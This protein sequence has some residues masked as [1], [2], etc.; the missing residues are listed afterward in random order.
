[1]LYLA[2]DIINKTLVSFNGSSLTV[3]G[4]FQ[5]N[6]LSLQLQFV[7]SVP[8]NSVVPYQTVDMNVTK[9]RVTISN[10]VTG[11]LASETSYELAQAVEAAFTW[12]A[13]NEWFTGVINLDTTQMATYLGSNASQPA[14][15]EVNVTT[16][17][18]DPETMFQG[19]VTVFA[20]ADSG[21]A[22]ST[23][24]VNG[25]GG[26]LALQNGVGGVTIAG[27]VITVAGL[28]WGTVPNA[29]LIFI[30]EPAAGN[31]VIFANY[32]IGSATGAGFQFELSGAPPN[33]N[34]TF[35]YV[36]VFNAPVF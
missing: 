4:L 17:G 21:G 26:T 33:N 16:G 11:V 30:H 22:P 27:T 13:I 23:T 18:S 9:P 36:P 32:I 7:Q 5:T 28:N 3:P 20:N 19:P 34:Y 29:V 12:D 35:T 6:E 1:M 25:T 14:I 2:F 8:G 24:P 31:G 15:I 10:K